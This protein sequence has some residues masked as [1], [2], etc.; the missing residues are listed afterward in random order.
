MNSTEWLGGIQDVGKAEVDARGRV[1]QDRV[2]GVRRAFI[3]WLQKESDVRRFAG[4]DGSCEVGGIGREEGDS[5]RKA[6]TSKAEGR[7]KKYP[8]SVLA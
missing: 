7:S 3:H 1:S 5:Q 2:T 8:E 4:Q 6:R